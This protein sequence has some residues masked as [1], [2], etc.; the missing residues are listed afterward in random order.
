MEFQVDADSL[1]EGY[2]LSANGFFIHEFDTPSVTPPTSPAPGH[3]GGPASLPNVAPV[4]I[5]NGT[6]DVGPEAGGDAGPEPGGD[7]SAGGGGGG[8][9]DPLS[10]NGLNIIT[11]EAT[12]NL[13]IP[14]EL[15]LYLADGSPAHA[16][17]SLSV[18]V[19]A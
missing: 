5:S 6:G 13:Q 18:R 14:D 9:P 2:L 10:V 19:A 16:L 8:V 15:I 11:N 7:A 3:A 12:G 17:E 4:S 1:S